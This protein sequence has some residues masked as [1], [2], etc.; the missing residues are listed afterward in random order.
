MAR[1]PYI[2]DEAMPVTMF[3][4][5]KA[6]ASETRRANLYRALPVHPALARQILATIDVLVKH[7]TLGIRLR[8]LVILRVAARSRC[9]Y[10]IHH[11]KRIA[12]RGG[13]SAQEINAALLASDDGVLSEAERLLLRYVDALILDVKA[14]GPLFDAVRA[15]LGLEKA[16]EVIHLVGFYMSLARFLETT[17]VDIESDTP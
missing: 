7:G 4:H 6:A 9:A 17:E 3:A 2:D 12:A 10:E 1:I 14:P 8:E 15:D 5:E 11:H 16:V 13:L